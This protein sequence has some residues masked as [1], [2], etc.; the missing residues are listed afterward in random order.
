M[1]TD[2]L[3]A[4]MREDFKESD[5]SNNGLN[6]GGIK[7]QFVQAKMKKTRVSP[8]R[9]LMLNFN[10]TTLAELYLP[11]T[12]NHEVIHIHGE[13]SKPKSVIFGYGDELD[14]D[15]KKLSEKTTTNTCAI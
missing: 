2:D 3:K 13:L 7:M 15:Y 6:H 10:Y 12:S 1:V 14:A 9:I 11:K 8:E 4:K 5:I